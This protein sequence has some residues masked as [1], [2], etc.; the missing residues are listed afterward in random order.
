MS[1]TSKA[2]S[3]PMMTISDWSGQARWVSL[4]R[5][6]R[7]P[8]ACSTAARDGFEDSRTIPF[9][10]RTPGGRFSARSQSVR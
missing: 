7:R 1:P 5:V 10:R 2:P 8:V 4:D 3:M 6:H 9:V